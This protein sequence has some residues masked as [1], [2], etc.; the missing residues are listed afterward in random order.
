MKIITTSE[1]AR[2]TAGGDDYSATA[3]KAGEIE[4]SVK[5]RR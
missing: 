5:N 3:A 2:A 4:E 1:L